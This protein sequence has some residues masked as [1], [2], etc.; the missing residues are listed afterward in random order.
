MGIGKIINRSLGTPVADVLADATNTIFTDV[1]AAI[2]AGVPVIQGT[3]KAVAAMGG[4]DTGYFAP[5]VAG[6]LQFLKEFILLK[7]QPVPLPNI[8]AAPPPPPPVLS[9]LTDG[10]GNYLTDGAG[11]RLAT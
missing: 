6:G 4:L 9:E 1:N 5:N 8:A 3:P 2:A 11:N 7:A 10:A